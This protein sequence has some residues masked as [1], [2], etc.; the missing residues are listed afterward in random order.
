MSEAILQVNFSLNVPVAEY[1]QICSSIAAAFAEVPGL[2]WKTW[3]LNEGAN[4]AGGIYLF[5]D[6]NALQA[7]LRSPLAAQ[8]QAHPAL[9]HFTAKPFDVMAEVSAVTRAPIGAAV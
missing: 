8:V 1:R 3:L 9:T 5:E 7:F 2:R 4:E 6:Q